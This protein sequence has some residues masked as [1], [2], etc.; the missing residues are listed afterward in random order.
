MRKL[1]PYS[2]KLLL[3]AFAGIF[4]FAFAGFSLH[5][6]LNTKTLNTISEDINIKSLPP[7]D[8][9]LVVQIID[10]SFYRWY[11]YEN[12]DTD[13]FFLY[14]L[15]PSRKALRNDE[16]LR[17]F[18]D[19]SQW[20]SEIP[21]LIYTADEAKIEIPA[22]AL[23][24]N[25]DNY[26]TGEALVDDRLPI[27][28]SD[29][30]D[31]PFNTVGF[32]SI[33]FPG[34]GES[35][36][37]MMR[38]TGFLIAPHTILTNAHC[39]YAN[40]KGGLFDSAEFFP[41]QYETGE[42][43]L[44]SP[45]P[46]VIPTSFGIDNNFIHYENLDYED[47]DTDYMLEAVKYDLAALFIIEPFEGISTFIPLEFNLKGDPSGFMIPGYP[48]VVRGNETKGMWLSEGPLHSFDE[49]LL[50]YEAFTSGGSSGSPV[51]H[52]NQQADTYRVYG[53]HS[54]TPDDLSYGGGPYFNENNRDMITGWMQFTPGETENGNEIDLFEIG[55]VNGDGD[56]NV[57]DVVLTI[58]HVL[59]LE[60]LGTEAIA[61][62]DVNKDGDIDIRDVT[63]IMRFSLGII[64]S[65]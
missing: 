53:I 31:F 6:F 3:A 49:F 9:R 42:T 29:T 25:N 51:L 59:E 2:K 63:L 8:I 52:Y 56:I 46:G 12:Q 58:R 16:V 20:E 33:N 19:S 38:G 24:F 5:S 41:G 22:S 43:E 44:V 62:A 32:L 14:L 48:G 1:Y 55:D 10:N 60:I 13:T 30:V 15:E 35:E 37:V 23:T 36:P 11:E 27:S 64:D 54:F 65:F 57:Y 18:T 21:R 28:G 47:N 4:L 7:G 39:L 45:F 40:D 34:T 17:L 61:R 26:Q 50:K